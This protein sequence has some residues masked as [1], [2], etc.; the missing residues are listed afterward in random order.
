[1]NKTGFTEMILR[2]LAADLLL[3]QGA[4]HL[5]V[6]QTSRLLQEEVSAFQNKQMVS[7]LILEQ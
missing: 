2:V 3:Y 5:L 4:L 1:M 7:I 6:I